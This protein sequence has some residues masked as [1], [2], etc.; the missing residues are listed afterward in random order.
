MSALEIFVRIRQYRNRADEFFRLAA[1]AFSLEVR[2]RYLVI[3]DHYITLAD[4]EVHSDRLARKKR[5]DG[6][7][8]ERERALHAKNAPTAD[9]KA[10]HMS[11]RH[12]ATP[13]TLNPIKL[14]VIQGAKRAGLRNNGRPQMAAQSDFTAVKSAP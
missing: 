7:R 14:R 10:T 12:P 3:A 6:M 5:L 4:A 13:R 8:S 2:E 11:A 1:G 9:L